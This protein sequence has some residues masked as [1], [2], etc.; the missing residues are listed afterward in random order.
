[1]ARKRDASQHTLRQLC[2]ELEAFRNGSS[3]SSAVVEANASVALTLAHSAVQLQHMMDELDAA[4]TRLAQ[5][6]SLS[7]QWTAYVQRLTMLVGLLPGERFMAVTERDDA[8]A[9][10]RTVT[11]ERDA[12]RTDFQ[13]LC[14]KTKA[15]AE[16]RR[17]V[18]RT[19]SWLRRDMRS[20]DRRHGAWYRDLREFGTRAQIAVQS[21][22]RMMLR[23]TW[24]RANR[25]AGEL[26]LYMDNIVTGRD[27]PGLTD[28]DFYEAYEELVPLQ[29]PGSPL[30]IFA[31]ER[32]ALLQLLYND[33]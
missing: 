10:V 30:R 20:M 28:K 17:D 9:T 24:S 4:R 12:Y 8:H 23:E 27:D 26:D 5:W 21:A 31:H 29:A 3:S 2:A 32:G 14:Q 16:A 33:P 25:V 13:T 1:M 15:F 6:M 11:A 18:D 22:A 7:G 19:I